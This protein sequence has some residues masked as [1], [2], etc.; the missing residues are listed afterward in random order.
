MKFTSPTTT[1]TG[2]ALL[3]AVLAQYLTASTVPGQEFEVISEALCWIILPI[4]FAFSKP[5]DTAKSNLPHYHQTSKA[6]SASIWSH[7]LASWVVALGVAVACCF[8]AEIGPIGLFVRTT[9]F[10]SVISPKL[11]I[12][13]TPL[14]SRRCHHSS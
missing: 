10:T 8:K 11:T 6:S 2:A 7:G 9:G 13:S 4:L 1:W 14:G 3:C 12:N 5:A